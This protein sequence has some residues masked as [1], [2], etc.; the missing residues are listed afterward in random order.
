MAPFGPV[1]QDRG[2]RTAE[3]ASPVA[4]ETASRSHQCSDRGG[5]SP[6]P[7]TVPAPSSPAL[8]GGQRFRRG[9]N[10]SPDGQGKG[11]DMTTTRTKTKGAGKR[12]ATRRA[13][14]RSERVDLYQEI[15]DEMIAQLE[16][17]T[18]PWVQ[19]WDS[20]VTS[21]TASATF[22]GMPQNGATGRTYSGIN[23]LILWI[24]AMKAGF[25]AQRWMTFQ[26]AKQLGGHVRKG[27]KSVRVVHAGTF[28]PKEEREAAA[29]EG[30]DEQARR[31]LKAHRVF[32]VSQIEGLPDE[33]VNGPRPPAPTFEGVDATVRQ[34]IE[35]GR[36]RFVTGSARAF[37][38]PGTDMVSV[39][40]MEAFADPAEWHSTT[41]H[42]LTHWTGHSTRLARDLEGFGRNR[43]DYAREELVAEI[44]AA[45]A[46]AAIG[47]L[48]RLRHAD[49]LATWLAVLKEDKHAIVRAASAASRASDF[50][51]SLAKEDGGEGF[52]AGRCVPLAA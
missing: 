37:Y 25:G 31:Y 15:T 47:T 40:P 17:G 48:P 16:A 51:L 28:T 6:S 19:P 14:E 9:L 1:V 5:R 11:S 32:N 7:A 41:L 49:Y 29:A 10:I 3:P 30:R 33:V 21:E 26:Q 42:E 44:G 24:R 36:V 52:T 35:R 20:S 46:A 38:Q 39:P 12:S 27:E 8:A 23:V 43:I 45:F 22:D 4:A 34:I 13:V 18:V 50:L 2:I